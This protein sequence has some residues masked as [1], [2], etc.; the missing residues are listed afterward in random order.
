MKAMAPTL[1]KITRNYQVTIPPAARRALKLKV[2]DFVEAT[3]QRNGVLLRP[4]KIV[5]EDS[6]EQELRRRLQEG[7]ADVKAGRTSG[8]F[9]TAEDLIAHLHRAASRPRPTRRAR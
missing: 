1:T 3:P 5:T 2:G 9:E 6:F 8:P 4:A 7:L